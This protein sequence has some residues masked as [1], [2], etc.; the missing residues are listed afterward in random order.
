MAVSPYFLFFPRHLRPR[1]HSLQADPGQMQNLASSFDTRKTILGRPI[2]YTQSRLDA[3]LMVL[4]SCKAKSCTDPW[5]VVHPRGDVRSLRDAMNAKYDDFYGRQPKV[6]FSK[7]EEGYIIE[8]EGP[9]V[10]LAYDGVQG[11]PHWT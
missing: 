5:S 6:A 10:G 9:Q 8:S 1:A 4:K 2:S 3:L 11:W 7:C